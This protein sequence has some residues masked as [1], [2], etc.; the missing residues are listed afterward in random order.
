MTRLKTMLAASAIGSLLLTA[1][2][3]YAG[4]LLD[5]VK[6]NGEVNCGVSTGIA[7][8]S[9]AD[10][11]GKWTG[12]TADFCRAVSSAVLGGEAKER[13]TPLNSTQ[14]F[15]AVQSGEVDLLA[16]TATWTLTRDASLGLLYAG[17]Y[18]YDGQGFL[19]DASLDINNPEELDGAT[20]CTATGTTNELNLA[21][22]FRSKN[23][24]FTPVV[25]ESQNEA[26]AA[27]FNGRCHA[28]SAD[29][30][31][32]SSVRAADAP[33]PEDW[34]LLDAAISKEPLGPVVSRNDLE[35]F[36]IVK[37]T[38]MALISAEEMGITAGNIDQMIRSDDPAIQRFLGVSGDMGEKLGLDPKWAYHLIKRVG[39]Y[40]ELYARNVG[41]N[42]PLRL[43]R[44]QNALSTA[45]GLMYAMPIR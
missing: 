6:E 28:L 12:L 40:G 9:I 31:Y 22:Y 43:E 3:V 20:I 38:L 14:R 19:V 36:T 30:T 45:G 44:G 33:N 7:G 4:E 25:F 35:W 2:P 18:F 27:L 17:V 13:Y 15:T 34:K 10:S 8:F 29:I 37:W 41:I 42:T 32:L 24:S 23:M 16:M 26:K 1:A 5:K 39:N 11:S 21:D